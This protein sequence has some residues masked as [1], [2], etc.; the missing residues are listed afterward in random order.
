MNTCDICKEPNQI[1]KH[2]PLSYFEMCDPCSKLDLL[3]L[4]D[5]A[6]LLNIQE[7]ALAARI[8]KGK[9]NHPQPSYKKQKVF[10]GGLTKTQS[11]WKR[12]EVDKFFKDSDLHKDIY[13]TKR[14]I[15]HLSNDLYSKAN[16]L[17]NK[18]ISRQLQD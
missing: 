2:A 14:I 15:S 11:L 4:G 18:N 13:K 1:T 7:L 3:K 6:E 5:V 12:S 9:G 17:F 16:L 10:E 8:R